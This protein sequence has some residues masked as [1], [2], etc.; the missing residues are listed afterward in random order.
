MKTKY[1]LK[2]S[3]ND[4]PFR[5]WIS[6]KYEVYVF[7]NNNKLQAINGVCPHYYGKLEL[8]KNKNQITCNFH[9]LKVCPNN[10][11]TNNKKFKKIQ[12]FK[13]VSNSPII[14]EI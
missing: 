7:K 2:N 5:E 3:I 4:V 9:H 14:I 10:L 12:S 8:N 6:I 13:I 11:T 1:K